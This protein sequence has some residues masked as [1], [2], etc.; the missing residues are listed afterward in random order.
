M[1]ESLQQNIDV[2]ISVRLLM[3]GLYVIITKITI[4]CSLIFLND[5]SI[6]E[7]GRVEE[8]FS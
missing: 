3:A 1:N 5:A 8:F 7:L 2:K 4:S 6:Y